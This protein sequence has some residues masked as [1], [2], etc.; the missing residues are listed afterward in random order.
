MYICICINKYIHHPIYVYINLDT[1]SIYIRVNTG[2]IF[3][4]IYIQIIFETYRFSYVCTVYMDTY[5]CVWFYLLML[6]LCSMMKY[7]L[8]LL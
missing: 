4:Y 7:T 3:V 5:M 8:P 1:H 2:Y 6:L